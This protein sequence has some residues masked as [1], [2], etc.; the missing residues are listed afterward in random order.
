MKRNSAYMQITRKCNNNCVF[1][2]NPSFDQEIN[3]EDIKKRLEYYNEK[4]ITEIVF[5]GGEPTESPYLLE[6]L[7]LA[8]RLNIKPKIIT[9]GVN[10]GDL[11]YVKSL[12]NN[13]LNHVHISLHSHIEKDSD[14]L[15]TK[16]GHYKKTIKGI[17]N[18]IDLEMVVN[19][20]TT[21]NSVNIP[22]LSDF[23]GFIIKE[24]PQIKHFVFNNLDP[25]DADKNL[26]SKAWENKWVI[27]KLI[28]MDLELFKTMRLLQSHDK[29]FR[30]ERVPLCYMNGFEHFATETRRLIKDESYKCIFIEKEKD[31]LYVEFKNISLGR[32]KGTVCNSCFLKDICAGMSKE[33][34]QLFG[35]NEIFAVFKSPDLIINRIKNGN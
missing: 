21:I 25:G 5:S 9:N 22:Y 23:I 1:C 17:M 31:D 18:C 15:T 4:G 16:K 35:D 10:L 13:G 12:R 27:A 6:A 28:D 20:N 29:T 34:F 3:L 2:S 32:H 7:T 24:Y 26:R 11:E 33:Y 14:R 30:I 19:I 8:K